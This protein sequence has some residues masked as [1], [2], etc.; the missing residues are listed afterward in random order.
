M[1]FDFDFD[2]D[3]FSL[4]TKTKKRLCFNLEKSA[5]I[6]S[7]IEFPKKMESLRLISS[8]NGWSSCSV[9]IAISK[10]YKIKNI[11]LTTLR[12][13]KKEMD[14]LC[15]IKDLHNC[16]VKIVMGGIAKE[17]GKY[18]YSEY[19]EENAKEKNIK[20]VPL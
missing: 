19:I 3:E 7:N 10:K 20:V 18:K 2:I 14:A 13:G 17:N 9:L 1:N 8:A 16:N 15:E 12:V 6:L 4:N 5:D 11:F